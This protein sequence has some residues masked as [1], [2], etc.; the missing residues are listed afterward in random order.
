MGVADRFEA[1]SAGRGD[2]AGDGGEGMLEIGPGAE[3]VMFFAIH[4]AIWASIRGSLL[5]SGD[6]SPFSQL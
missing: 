6:C 1:L 4:E 3:I 2:A 5:L